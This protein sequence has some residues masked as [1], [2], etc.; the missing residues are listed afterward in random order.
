MKIKSP[1]SFVNILFVC[2]FALISC[3]KSPFNEEVAP[4]PTTIQGRVDLHRTDGDNS[5]AYIWLEGI[6]VATHT[7][8][9]GH[10]KL[11]IPRERSANVTG[12]YKLFCYVANYTLSTA[13]IIVQDGL[14]KYGQGDLDRLGQVNRVVD[15]F[16][17]LDISTVVQPRWAAINDSGVFRVQVTLKAITDSVTVIFPKS[18]GGLLGGLFFRNIETGQIHIDIP[19]EGADTRESIVVGPEQSFKRQGVFQLNGTNFRD[20]TLPVG[21]YEIIPYFFIYHESL[22]QELLDSLGEKVEEA[23][24]EFLKIPFKREGGRFRII[25]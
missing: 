13:E 3:T 18:V 5:N 22:P 23:D 19:D 2:A 20:L 4:P 9:L 10:F 8:S 1:N 7:D 16:Q 14:F 25:G 12:S 15:L 24:P 17:S 21:T 11:E 6:N